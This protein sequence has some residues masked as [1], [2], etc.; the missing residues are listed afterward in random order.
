MITYV[1]NFL[2]PDLHY[3]YDIFVLI[4]PISNWVYKFEALATLS[5][6]GRK[7]TLSQVA[8]WLVLL[9]QVEVA[10]PTNL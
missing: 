4:N 1:M 9:E 10:I 7:K 8:S 5:Q 2:K 6:G 3:L